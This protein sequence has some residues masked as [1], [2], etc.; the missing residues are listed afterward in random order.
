MQNILE[1]TNRGCAVM[2]EIDATKMARKYSPL[3]AMQFDCIIFNFPHAGVFKNDAP[4]EAQLRIHQELISKFLANAKMMMKM[5]GEIHI[6]HKSN[7]FFREWNIQRLGENEGLQLIEAVPFHLK[8]YEGY[9]TKL[10]YGEALSKVLVSANFYDVQVL[11][12]E[13]QKGLSR[14]ASTVGR[15]LYIDQRRLRRPPVGGVVVPVPRVDSLPRQAQM[16]E[17]SEGVLGTGGDERERPGLT[18]DEMTA[19]TS[20]GGAAQGV[21]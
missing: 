20:Y 4:R 11:E 7:G 5:D 15:P 21:P 10:G 3:R 9:G 12:P 14:I 2:H 8:E 16:D 6:R 13:G 19:C 17:L 18:L 1:L